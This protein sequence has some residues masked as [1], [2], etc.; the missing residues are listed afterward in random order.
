MSAE[1]VD[2]SRPRLVASA[3]EVIEESV[4]AIGNVAESDRDQGGDKRVPD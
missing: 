2:R 1:K 4:K 3:G